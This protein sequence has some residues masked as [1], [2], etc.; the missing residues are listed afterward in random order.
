MNVAGMC[1]GIWLNHLVESVKR[2]LLKWMEASGFQQ[3]LMWAKMVRRLYTL[4][5]V[6]SKLQENAADCAAITK[7]G[8][9]ALS[10]SFGA[11]LVR[12]LEQHILKHIALRRIQSITRA[13]CPLLVP[14]QNATFART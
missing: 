4:E 10:S 9:S 13:L 3:I 6:L 12:L 2:R 5:V 14:V 7:K 1:M 8:Q 11:D